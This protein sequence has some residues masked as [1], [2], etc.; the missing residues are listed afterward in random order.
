MKY[1][2]EKYNKPIADKWIIRFILFLVIILSLSSGYFNVLLKAESKK[3]L[4]LEDLY[5]RV[6][7]ELGREETQRLIDL[8]RENM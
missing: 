6:R 1:I 4:K 5:V 2:F 8:S 7:S 3:Y